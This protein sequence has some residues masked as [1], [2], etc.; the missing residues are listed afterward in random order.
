MSF[1]FEHLFGEAD[2]R[3]RADVDIKDNR[4]LLRYAARLEHEGSPASAAIVLGV[5]ASLNDTA[6]S[7]AALGRLS[8]LLADAGYA[9]EAHSV[10][11]TMTARAPAEAPADANLDLAARDAAFGNIDRA[12]ERYAIVFG[13]GGTD[14]ALAALRVAHL[15]LGRGRQRAAAFLLRFAVENGDED[16]LPYALVDLAELLAGVPT[17]RDEAMD[18]YRRAVETDHADLAPAAAMALAQLHVDRHEPGLARRLYDLV[19][20]S[21]HPEHAPAA[22]RRL[23]TLHEQPIST[24]TSPIDDPTQLHFTA[25]VG[26]WQSVVQL[27]ALGY[28]DS[29]RDSFDELIGHR[30]CKQGGSDPSWA[31]AAPVGVTMIL[32]I[33]FPG[34]SARI[35]LISRPNSTRLLPMRCSAHAWPNEERERSAPEQTMRAAY[36]SVGVPCLARQRFGGAEM[37]LAR[38]RTRR[39]VAL[40]VAGWRKARGLGP[41]GTDAAYVPDVYAA[42]QPFEQPACYGPPTFD[43][44]RDRV[45]AGGG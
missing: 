36:D 16:V 9:D 38:P 15:E 6:L 45:L 3:D 34:G 24:T 41:A 17:T 4:E 10:M 1:H 37:L 29:Q 8:R 12:L 21:G 33:R 26:R 22:R 5:L 11:T 39:L 19:V 20:S 30:V 31:G 18:L 32:P 7:F 13:H 42:S 23:D 14:A 43:E 25:A 44:H 28:S 40:V 35:D 27:V 2:W